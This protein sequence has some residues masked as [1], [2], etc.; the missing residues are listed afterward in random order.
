MR[1]HSIKFKKSQIRWN[2]A[3]RMKDIQG[4]RL[5]EGFYYSYLAMPEEIG[6]RSKGWMAMAHD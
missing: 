5:I 2:M 6:D 3:Q 1:I 4:Q